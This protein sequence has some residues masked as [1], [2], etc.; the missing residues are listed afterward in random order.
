MGVFENNLLTDIVIPDSVTS[1]GQQAFQ[2]NQ[3]TAV[4]V[5]DS[6]TFI[7]INAFAGNKLTRITIGS[8]VE[9]QVDLS[10]GDYTGGFGSAF[11]QIYKEHGRRAG[12]YTYRDSSWAVEFR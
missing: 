9:F 7:E 3:L 1:I 11:L 12:T 2:N 10:R 8:N 4:T 6:V 5:P